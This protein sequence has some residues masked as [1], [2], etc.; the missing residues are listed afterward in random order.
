[1]TGTLREAALEKRLQ[2]TQDRL[3]NSETLRSDMED[4]ASRLRVALSVAQNREVSSNDM[5]IG[6]RTALTRLRDTDMEEFS[7][8]VA[9]IPSIYLEGGYP[10]ADFY[11]RFKLG[12]MIDAL[13][14]AAPRTADLARCLHGI[15]AML[16]GGQ[17]KCLMRADRAGQRTRAD[18]CVAVREYCFLPSIRASFAKG[19]ETPAGILP[20]QYVRREG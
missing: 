13:S 4:E 17:G 11:C 9:K 7:T 15:K 10:A 20:V 3:E 16:G 5:G 1:M 2:D 18:L 6:G 8:A 14:F 19:V 12:R